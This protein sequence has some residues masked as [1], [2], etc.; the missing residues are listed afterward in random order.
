MRTLA[1]QPPRT[2]RLCQ[3]TCPGP[4]RS[5]R[6]EPLTRPQVYPHGA[7]GCRNN[8]GMRSMHTIAVV[9]G[10]SIHAGDARREGGGCRSMGLVYLAMHVLPFTVFWNGVTL[11]EGGL[12]LMLC[13]VLMQ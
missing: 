11:L 2:R 4:S 12:C 10:Q 5:T 1:A 7:D 3:G 6:M 13:L 8:Q 9:A